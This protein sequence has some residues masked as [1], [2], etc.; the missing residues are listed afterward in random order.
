MNFMHEKVSS[1]S[2]VIDKLLNGGFEKGIISTLFGPAGAG[3]SN[4]AIITAT[5]LAKKGYVLFIDTEGSFSVERF[6]QVSGNNRMLLKRILLKRLV[7]FDEQKQ[8]IS[9]LPELVK[10]KQVSAIIMDSII[11]LYRLHLGSEK[12]ISTT[13][14][15]LANQLA[16]LS[17]VA[18]NLNLPVIV[19]NQVY[20]DFNKPNSVHM[21]GGD[22]LKY[23]SKC[24]I[25]LEPI[26]GVRKASI[27]KHRSLPEGKCVFF[28]ITD[29]GLIEVKE[30]KRKFSLF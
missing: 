9:K 4:I 18:R 24:I 8:Y 6:H 11:M 19:T 10:K 7:T 2:Q 26:N 28:D 27:Y 30:P 15:D 22:L 13:N 25:K 1:G 20:S 3:K 14:K 5:N 29:K 16:I 21:V 23:W 17:A 12:D